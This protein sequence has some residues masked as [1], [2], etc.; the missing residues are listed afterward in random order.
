MY[1]LFCVLSQEGTILKKYYGLS[2]VQGNIIKQDKFCLVG[3]IF[4]NN[5]YR[6]SK[7]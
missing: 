1:N 5:L 4:Q 7:T 3:K 6:I 2:D